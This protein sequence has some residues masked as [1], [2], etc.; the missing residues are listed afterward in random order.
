MGLR[1]S[2]CPRPILAPYL[3]DPRL[4]RRDMST[5]DGGSCPYSN[6][7]SVPSFS[8]YPESTNRTRLTRVRSQ[9]DAQEHADPTNQKRHPLHFV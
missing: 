4:T 7:P 9:G 5:L 8:A 3:P 2:A 6:V 1:P